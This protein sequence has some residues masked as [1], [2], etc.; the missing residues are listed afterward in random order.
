M[1][2]RKEY[3]E[4]IINGKKADIQNGSKAF[5]PANIAL[6]KYWGKRDKELNLPLTDSLSVSMGNCGTLTSVKAAPG[7]ENIIIFNGTELSAS[8]PFAEKIN[9][10]AALMKPDKGPA[11]EIATENN[12]PTA[13]GAASSASGF[14]A[15][16]LALD[17]F[18]GY[19]LGSRE[20][21]M[22]A[23]IGSRSA[24]RS[25]FT[26]FVYN[27][28]G[29][30]IDGMDAFSEKLPYEWPEMRLGLVTVSSEKKCMSSGKGMEHTAGTSILYERWPSQVERDMELILK[31]LNEKNFELL[32][33]TSENNALSMHACMLSS[34]PPLI[35]WE[36]ET[37]A[38][39]KT[40]S[41]ARNEGLSC[42]VT[43]DAG[44]NVKLIFE[45]KDE[46]VIT[47]MFPGIRVISPFS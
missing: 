17:S 9:R 33:K 29:Q 2:T 14:A 6:C 11:L 40:V 3:A 39:I 46:N 12:I 22:L 10:F 23:G 24:S 26:G 30:R 37:L 18:Y 15:L 21:S 4:K 35:Y 42:Y 38:V 20:L 25:I 36:P 19:G 45:K 34:N 43:I 32:G 5:A 31:A 7:K 41:K 8:S 44:A 1:L 47:G 13:A 28:R 16:T 27:H